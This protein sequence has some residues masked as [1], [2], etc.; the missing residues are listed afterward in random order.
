[1]PLPRQQDEAHEI[2]ERIDQSDDLGCQAAAGT[3]AGQSHMEFAVVEGWRCL[4]GEWRYQLGSRVRERRGT[5]V[6][7]FLCS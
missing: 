2:A 6:G 1:V 7:A 5:S 4:L 3:P